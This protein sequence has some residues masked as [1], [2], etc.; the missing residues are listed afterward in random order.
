MKFLRAFTAA[1]ALAAA[2]ASSAVAESIARAG[3]RG[4]N[5]TP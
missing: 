2:G 1:L 4:V 5:V 3:L